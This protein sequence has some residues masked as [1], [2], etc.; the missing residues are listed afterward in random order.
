MPRLCAISILV[1][2]FILNMGKFF[3]KQVQIVGFHH[4]PI[5]TDKKI[6][7]YLLKRFLYFHEH[8]GS[9]EDDDLNEEFTFVIPS[10]IENQTLPSRSDE[11]ISI[12][13]V[14]ENFIYVNKTLKKIF[15]SN[16]VG[17]ILPSYY[18]NFCP[19]LLPLSMIVQVTCK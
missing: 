6:T 2:I 9:A 11:D 3:F 14:N 19:L 18:I 13:D 4:W 8:L 7:I 17:V 16:G 5:S 15:T 10:E 12:D 1:V